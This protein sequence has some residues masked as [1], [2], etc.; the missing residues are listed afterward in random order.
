MRWSLQAASIHTYR[1]NQHDLAGWSLRSSEWHL[2]AVQLFVGDNPLQVLFKELIPL[3][4]YDWACVC[5]FV[6]P[7][8]VA[9]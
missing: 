9:M 4:N 5:P 2:Y 3:A 7:V 1:Q 6:Q 8:I